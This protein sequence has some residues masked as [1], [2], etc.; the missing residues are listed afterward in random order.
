MGFSFLFVPAEVLL[1]DAPWT[2][3]RYI[4]VGTC[5]AFIM[6]VAVDFWVAGLELENRKLVESAADAAEAQR[7]VFPSKFGLQPDAAGIGQMISAVVDLE[8]IVLKQKTCAAV[9]GLHLVAGKDPVDI[10]PVGQ[11]VGHGCASLVLDAGD[12]GVLDEIRVPMADAALE[13]DAVRVDVFDFTRVAVMVA[14]AY[15][16]WQDMNCDGLA[17]FEDA[18]KVIPPDDMIDIAGVQV[19]II[20][21]IGAGFRGVHHTGLELI[22]MFQLAEYLVPA[23]RG[24]LPGVDACVGRDFR[25]Q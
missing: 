20:D 8:E 19:H 25:G 13:N 23:V 4:P 18:A 9:G 11:C 21:R 24:Q 16:M 17:L 10:D 22:D 1:L 12:G 6:H 3:L 7:A 14:T 5:S 2:E 15:V